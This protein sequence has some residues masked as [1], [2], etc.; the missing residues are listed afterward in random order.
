MKTNRRDPHKRKLFADITSW[1]EVAPDHF[2][3]TEHGLQFGVS[4][5]SSQHVGLFLDQRDSRRRIASM[6]QGARIANLFAFTCSFSISALAAGAREVF[7]VDLAAG[8]LNR[9]RGNLQTNG[10]TEAGISRFI[11]EDVRK[12]LARQVRK[13]QQNPEEFL[14]FDIVV[15]DPPVFA[16]AG[17]GKRFHVE[18]EWQGLARD[19]AEIL[20]DEGVALF[21][22]NHQAGQE[23]HYYNGLQNQF[24]K[25]TRLNPPLDFPVL[26]GQPVHVR[27]YWCEK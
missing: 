16:S 9:G 24:R 19:V 18:K 21:A 12:W 20:T 25:V 2:L 22:N 10:L 27:I 17:K 13:K 1:G 3:V 8:C 15:C 23:S 5:N 7:S 11:K 26:K 14:P 4:L 6:A